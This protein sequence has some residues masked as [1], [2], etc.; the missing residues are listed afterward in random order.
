M[1]GEIRVV[2]PRA[3]SIKPEAP[4][5]DSAPVITI[6]ADAEGDDPPAPPPK[7]VPRRKTRPKTDPPE[8]AARTGEVDSR[9]GPIQLVSDE[10]RIVIAEDAYNAP[11]VPVTNDGAVVA[12]ARAA[13][14]EITRELAHVAAASNPSISV[15]ADTGDPDAPVLI[16]D[17]GDQQSQPILLDGRRERSTVRRDAA[18]RARRGRRYST[19]ASRARAPRS[20]R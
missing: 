14:A 3:S 18:G 10:P 5:D 11:T 8:L 1:S 20:A 13:S 12:V 7:P 9:T 6:E 4:D 19:R 16:H 15:S 2:K 17:H